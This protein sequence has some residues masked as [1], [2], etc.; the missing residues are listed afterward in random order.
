MPHDK[1]GNV[2]KVGDIVNVPC[3][4][5]SISMG[6]EYCNVELQTIEKM[7]PSDNTSTMNLNAKQVEFVS[8]TKGAASY[9][10]QVKN[11]T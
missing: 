3:K 4:I 9:E 11:G 6:E 8:T 1:N 10:N 5:K 7:F 2:L